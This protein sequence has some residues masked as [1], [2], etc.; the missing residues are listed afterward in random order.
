MRG[1]VQHG[2]R[3]RACG[4]GDGG[5]FGVGCHFQVVGRIADHQSFLRHQPQFVAEFENHVGC[6]FGGLLAGAGGRHPKIGSTGLHDRA[7]ESYPAFTRGDGEPVALVLQ[8]M[9]AG[10]G[11][12]EERHVVVVGVEIV[13]G[14]G[15]RQFFTHVFAG[16]RGEAADDFGQAVTDE[17]ADGIVIGDGHAAVGKTLLEGADNRACRV[18]QR[19]VPVEDNQFRF[20]RALS[21][22]RP[23]N[24]IKIIA[25][26]RMSAC[27]QIDANFKN[28]N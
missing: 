5:G 13:C 6:G 15:F 12:G 8:G 4:E 14:V 22:R 21:F 26:K 19:S 9:Q 24:K 18:C 17:G 1:G 2:G 11:F 23:V 28:P 7:V 27:L 16:M 3:V 25:E 10:Q 20:H